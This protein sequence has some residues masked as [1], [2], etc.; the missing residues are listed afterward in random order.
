VPDGRFLSKSVSL[1]EQLE[2]VSIEAAL[3]FTWCI[4]H[5]DSEGRMLGNPAAVKATAV[6][7]RKEITLERLPALLFELA[8]APK[9][10]RDRPLV[11]WYEVQ[12]R[13]LL[14]FPGFSSHQ[15]GQRKD[16]E[17]KSRL[18]SRKHPQARD[19]A[20]ASNPPPEEGGTN[21]GVDPDQLHLSEEK[22][23]VS[24][25]KISVGDQGSKPPAGFA[26][27]GAPPAETPG[28]T[29]QEVLQRKERFKA[30]I[31]ELQQE[32]ARS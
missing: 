12:N 2:G 23:Y 15:R 18:P 5:L 13:A 10:D 11:Y 26:P 8:T 9:D 31:R 7:L 27:E 17:A 6:P 25:S 32:E 20:A 4:P 21:S 3:L 29:A 14:E 30:G 24:T 1:S 16:R 22:E 28:L 19:L